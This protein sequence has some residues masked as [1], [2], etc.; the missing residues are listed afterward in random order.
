MRRNVFLIVLALLTLIACQPKMGSRVDTGNLSVFF[1]QGVDK[2]K[3]IAFAEYW[4]DNGFVGERKQTIQLDRD[5][6]VILV[7]LIENERFHEELINI[8]EEAM[9]QQI[10]RDLKRNVFQQEVEI[11]ITDNTLRPLLKRKNI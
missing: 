5:G 8:S 9:L 1:L 6:E 3:A 7:K 2:E 11:V 10:E 4:R